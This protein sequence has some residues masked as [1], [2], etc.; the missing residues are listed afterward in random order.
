VAGPSRTA[1]RAAGET[2]HGPGRPATP[3][4]DA[5]RG[6]RARRLP[7][8][9]RPRLR[10]VV[11]CA[12]GLLL[13]GSFAVWVLFFSHW[14][15]VDHVSV[16]GQDVLTAGQLRDAADISPG[17]PLASVDEDAVRARLLKRLPR[18]HDVD[19][20][21]AWPHGIGLKVTERQPVLLMRT[22]S[23]RFTEV[24]DEGV[25]FA[26]VRTAPPHVPLLELHA[27]GSPT[28]RY[29]GTDRLRR[30]AVHIAAALPPEIARDTR[31]VV[32][33]SYDAI[34]LRLTGGRTVVWGSG[35]Q[36]KAK[37]RSLSA[38]LKAARHATH[39]DVTVPTSPAAS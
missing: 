32:V 24:D 36:S 15:R 14:L 21:R 31:T 12:A 39:Y 1:D 11:L 30:E 34:T 17:T 18:L 3:R 9:P 27:S 22:S 2:A 16:D 23:G 28:L 20:V 13:V 6:V 29:F 33:R 37:A 35:E 7:R 26:T 19:V 10:A 38:L 8:V 5:A 4:P 25:R